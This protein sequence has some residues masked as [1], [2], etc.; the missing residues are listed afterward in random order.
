MRTGKTDT[1]EVIVKKG[2]ETDAAAPLTADADVLTLGAEGLALFAL[3]A[4]QTDILP[5]SYKMIFKWT[6]GNGDTYYV[7]EE[8]LVVYHRIFD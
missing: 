5:G 8:L 1:V 3:T 4:A 7:G 6:R 2:S